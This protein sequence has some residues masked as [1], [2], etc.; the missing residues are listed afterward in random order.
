[1]KK[2]GTMKKIFLFSLTVF[3]L[4]LL[5]MP[6]H[7]QTTRIALVLP[8]QA[9]PTTSNAG[10]LQDA[11][12]K[13]KVEYQLPFPGILP[14]N[15]LY[16]LKVARDRIMELLIAEPVRKTEFYILQA[17]KRLGMGVQLLEKGNSALAETTLSKGETYMDKA[18]STAVNY[19]TSGKEI[20][21]YLVDRLS[22]SLMKHN[23][24]LSEEVVKASETIKPALSGFLET[25]KKLQ[26]EAEKLK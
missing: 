14:D 9:T 24:V 10:V 16:M 15:P 13:P 3:V 19:K 25:V 17:D 2:G 23:E 5:S 7:A 18:V 20:P 11:T 4:S 12:V 26:T 22:R 1:M 6:V 8:S 21:G